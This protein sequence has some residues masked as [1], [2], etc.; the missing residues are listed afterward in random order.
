VPLVTGLAGSAAASS[1]TEPSSGSSPYFGRWAIAEERPVYTARGA[2]YKMIDI[3]PCGR[4]FCGVSVGAGGVCGA[5]LFR[6]LSSH[7][8]GMTVLQ[9]H[10][11][12]GS[13]RKNVQIGVVGGE[14]PAVL[15]SLELYLGDGHDFGGRS[16]NMPKFHGGYRSLGA[17]Q[18]TAR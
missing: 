9:G 13:G 14:T 8:D 1:A 3:A 4:D 12:W 6:F 17:A 7:R 15:R 5:T 18:C 2:A 16:D 11:R 10:G